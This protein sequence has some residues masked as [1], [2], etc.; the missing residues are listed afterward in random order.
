MFKN[1]YILSLNVG[2]IIQMESYKDGLT[3]YLFKRITDAIRKK[4]NELLQQTGYM[5]LADSNSDE[6]SLASRKICHQDLWDFM[7]TIANHDIEYNIF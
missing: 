3:K 6:A 1:K 4:S 5:M 7:I 2:T